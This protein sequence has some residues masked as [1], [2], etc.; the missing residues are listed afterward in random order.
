VEQILNKGKS[1]ITHRNA[2]T[3]KITTAVATTIIIIF[4]FL[5]A[6]PTVAGTS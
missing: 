2:K 4:L 5:C 6:N 3:N 1:L